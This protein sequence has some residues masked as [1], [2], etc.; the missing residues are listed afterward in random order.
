[1]DFDLSILSDDIKWREYINGNIGHREYF[2]FIKDSSKAIKV[3]SNFIGDILM[4]HSVKME[5]GEYLRTIRMLAGKFSYIISFEDNYILLEVIGKGFSCIDRKR[6]KY[7]D[8][9][10]IAFIIAHRNIKNCKHCV[11]R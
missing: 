2:G 11:I 7:D 3:F 10:K 9:Q 6:V 1:M 4:C 8:A 5:I